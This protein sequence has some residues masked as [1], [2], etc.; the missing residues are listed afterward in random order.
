VAQED[1][2]PKLQLSRLRQA[3]GYRLSV[4]DHLAGPVLCVV[5][6]LASVRNHRIIVPLSP[7][8]TLEANLPQMW[9]G[10]SNPHKS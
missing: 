1:S 3:E 2:L 5:P 8:K 6:G 10:I 9:M 4:M 7:A